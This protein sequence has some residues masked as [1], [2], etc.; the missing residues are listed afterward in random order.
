MPFLRDSVRKRL[1]TAAAAVVAMF[2]GVGVVE[3]APL[4]LNLA[5]T[6]ANT[7]AMLSAGQ[8]AD[9]TV[10]GDS[11]SARPGTYLPSLTAKLQARYGDAG[12]GYQGF[13]LWTGAGFNGGWLNTGI[14]TDNPPHHSLDGLWNRYDG[15]TGWPNNSVF[16]PRNTE[17]ELHYMTQPGG[18][19]FQ[20]RR[21]DFG[22]VHTTISTDGPAGGV[23]TY[24]YT[25][26]PGETQY[27]IVP[28]GGGSFT[29]LGQNN[30]RASPGVRV[31]RA[32]N[33][34]WG[35]NNF[36]Q[37][38]GTFDQQLQL[39]DTDLFVVWIG[40]NDQG[41]TR[42]SYA[43]KINQLVDRLYAAVPDAR[44]LL[45][46][47]YD[48]GSSPLAGLVE[49]MADVAQ[50]RGLGFINLYRAAGDA[51]F[52]NG[53]GY[54]DD[55]IHFSPAGGEYL[56]ELLYQAF[57]SDGRSLRDPRE[58]VVPTYGVQFPTGG[59]WAAPSI[60]PEPATGLAGVVALAFLGG[61]RPRK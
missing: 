17:V 14:N 1:A 50:A 11:L 30:L 10:L 38:D 41:F 58:T 13:S 53:H 18:G 32:A 56:A 12:A 52:F 48:Q 55:G 54:L 31:H 45:I 44:I 22:A 27:S 47:T 61:R 7:K 33:G 25:L 36:L 16:T 40:Q 49:A 9:I 24:R 42:Q 46:G 6:L 5:A 20:I 2:S 19:S 21:G 29:I 43:P 37:R 28:A 26:N 4:S 60:I 57:I 59:E 15:V 8:R 35:V 34:G 3:A 51:A 23:A 39:V